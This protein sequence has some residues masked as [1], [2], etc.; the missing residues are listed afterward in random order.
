MKI[1]SA[2]FFQT[3]T[4]SP[5]TVYA[6]QDNTRVLDQPIRADQYGEL[7]PIF[8]AGP[9]PASRYAGEFFDARGKLI[10]RFDPLNAPVPTPWEIMKSMFTVA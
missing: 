1:Q 4:S 9:D 6:D 5:A 10:A 7:P 8:L 2:K 3:G